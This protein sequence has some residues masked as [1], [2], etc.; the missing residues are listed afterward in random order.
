MELPPNQLPD[1]PRRDVP[2]VPVQAVDPAHA[3]LVSALRGSFAIL[4]LIMVVLVVLYLTS[5]VFQIQPGEQGLIAR[6]GR[7]VTNPE[8]GA[9]VFT[10]GWIWWALPDPF[11]EKIRIPGRNLRLEIETFL[12]QRSP[13]DRESRKDLAGIR[14][15]AQTLRPGVDGALLTGDKN[16]CHGLWEVEYRI[17][18]A[19]RFVTHA[20]ERPADFEPLLQRLL[21]SAVLREASHRTVDEV[22][23]LGVERLTGDVRGRLQA[24]LE[25]LD[26]GVEVVKVRAT[27]IVPPQVAS[28]FADVTRAENEKKQQEH[29]AEQRATEILNQMA[30]PQHAVV[31]EQIQRYGAAQLAGAPAAELE[32]LRGGIDAALQEASGDVAARLRE[33]QAA[34]NTLRQQIGRE[35]EEYTYWHEQFQR[36]PQATLI[37]LWAQMR[38]A[39]LDSRDNEVFWVPQ[40]PEIEIVV[41]RDPNRVIEAEKE[42]LRRQMEPSPP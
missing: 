37:S 30:G 26:V 10:K 17:V 32:R 25:R 34:A 3:A 39:V 40:G 1:H 31:L 4:R 19:A 7:L 23:R 18:D 15:A 14:T 2:D 29:A 38:Q 27:T 35:Y 36:Y 12:F 21:E 24:E 33:A 11:D 5:G 8:S 41:N 16:L 20:A 28:A 42:R 13:E 6:L 22:T 9:P